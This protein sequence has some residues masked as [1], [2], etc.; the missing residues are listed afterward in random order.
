[1]KENIREFIIH[2]NRAYC[3][4]IGNFQVMNGINLHKTDHVVHLLPKSWSA[5][6]PITISIVVVHPYYA[7]MLINLEERCCDFMQIFK[8][9]LALIKI[10]KFSESVSW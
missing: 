2:V 3:N 7:C 4:A 10:F 9:L 8:F 6:T 1:M 5:I